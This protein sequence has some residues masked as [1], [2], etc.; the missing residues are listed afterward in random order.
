MNSNYR[1]LF[2]MPRGQCSK[3]SPLYLLTSRVLFSIFPLQELYIFFPICITPTPQKNAL[4]KGRKFP[5]TYYIPKA[6]PLISLSI[7]LGS[8]CTPSMVIP[9]AYGRSQAKSQIGAVATSLRHSHSN[10]GSLTHGARPG[11]EPTS[12]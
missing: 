11:I 1:A 5:V 12:S 9:A 10:T 3:P 6:T 7:S 2:G 4:V 8:H